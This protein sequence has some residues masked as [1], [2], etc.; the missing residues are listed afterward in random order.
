MNLFVFF[1]CYLALVPSAFGS[2]L[3]NGLPSIMSTYLEDILNFG[4]ESVISV[5][6]QIVGKWNELPEKIKEI[7]VS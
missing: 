7:V 3:Y 1:V 6:K 2:I 5:Q 4:N